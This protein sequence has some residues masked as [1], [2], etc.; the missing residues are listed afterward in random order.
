M[1]NNGKPQRF[2][3]NKISYSLAKNKNGDVSATYFSYDPHGN[4]EWL[5]PELPG[6][7]LSVIEYDY[8]LLSKNVKQVTYNPGRAD[9][10][11]HRF[12]HDA[13]D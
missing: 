13:D 9:E 7:G 2:L 12:M 5:T 8:D 11:S 1:A 10:F 6:L 4:I 3:D